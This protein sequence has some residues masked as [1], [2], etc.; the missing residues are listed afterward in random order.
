MQVLSKG[1]WSHI[2]SLYDR[3]CACV[4]NRWPRGCGR[5]RQRML[6]SSRRSR[7]A[8]TGHTGTVPA[9]AGEQ[10]SSSA[11]TLPRRDQPCRSA[12]RS[13]PHSLR[14][15]RLAAWVRASD[16]SGSGWQQGSL[17]TPAQG[18]W[19]SGCARVLAAGVADQDTA[20]TPWRKSQQAGA[21]VG[22]TGGRAAPP[23]DW[24]RSNRP[25]LPNMQG[26]GQMLADCTLAASGAAPAERWTGLHRSRLAQGADQGLR[27]RPGRSA[28]G[29]ADGADEPC[30]PCHCQRERRG[31]CGRHSRRAYA[32][33]VRADLSSLQPGLHGRSCAD[34]QR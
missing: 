20:C 16:E 25:P 1:A 24:R 9:R 34:D 10:G 29:S 23:A 15:T 12:S 8:W 28:L 19:Q 14:L 32:G 11:H 27:R 7:A 5:H 26:Q 22:V 18:R 21:R 6:D 33:G 30:R 31:A 4:C 13:T 2:H 17:Y 3:A